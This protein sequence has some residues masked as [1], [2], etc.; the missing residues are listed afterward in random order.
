[1]SLGPLWP[2]LRQMTRGARTTDGLGSAGTL[3]VLAIVLQLMVAGA[4][5]ARGDA[6]V[7]MGTSVV[8]TLRE[9]V[10][11]DAPRLPQG[12]VEDAGEIAQAPCPSRAPNQPDA[13]IRSGL[14]LTA[15]PPPAVD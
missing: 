7:R 6:S 9:V 14:W 11:H 3:A 4:A 15:V 13:I 12:S 10:E 8:H 5:S 2:I 1:M